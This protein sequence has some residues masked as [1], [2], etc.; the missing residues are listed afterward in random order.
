MWHS[1]H[2][3]T[4]ILQTAHY[5]LRNYTFTFILQFL[6]EQSQ[7]C[8]RKQPRCIAPRFPI[9]VILPSFH[10]KS[11]NNSPS[12]ACQ[13]GYFRIWQAYH[14][15]A[16]H[17]TTCDMT[18]LLNQHPITPNRCLA[19]R[20]AEASACLWEADHRAAE[21]FASPMLCLFYPATAASCVCYQRSRGALADKIKSTSAHTARSG[22]RISSSL[23][24]IDI[25]SRYIA[26]NEEV[27]IAFAST[28]N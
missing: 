26:G 13:V 23:S 16:I 25:T 27:D 22:G 5:C 11:Y 21:S 28:Y 10:F 2:N 9:F 3:C 15:N 12:A 7:R 20:W 18:R 1:L 6:C 8:T 24:Q 4:V 19:S 14:F 17:Q